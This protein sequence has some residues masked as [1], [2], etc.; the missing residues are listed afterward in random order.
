MLGSSFEKFLD[1]HNTFP[2]ILATVGNLF[3]GTPC[4]LSYWGMRYSRIREL[5]SW[6]LIIGEFYFKKKWMAIL[7]LCGKQ[8]PTRDI[9]RID[10]PS[11]YTTCVCIEF[12]QTLWPLL[13]N[14]SCSQD[15]DHVHSTYICCSYTGS[16]QHVFHPP[17]MFY[18]CTG[19]RHKKKFVRNK[20]SEFL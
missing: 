11:T 4:H 5:D 19:R 12:G 16:T 14:L 9:Y 15:Q 1:S 3:L 17:K 13:R 18:S 10:K 20:C 8:W 6:C 7:L 2:R